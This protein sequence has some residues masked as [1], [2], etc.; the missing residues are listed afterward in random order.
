M[1]SRQY[2][3]FSRTN[4]SNCSRNTQRHN[5]SN[6][7]FWIIRLRKRQTNGTLVSA[8]IKIW[9]LEEQSS[10]TTFV[11]NQ[12]K[13][14][15]IIHSQHP[16]IVNQKQ[17]AD[18]IKYIK[19]N[20]FLSLC[21]INKPVKEPFFL[22]GV[23]RKTFWAHIRINHNPKMLFDQYNILELLYSLHIFLKGVACFSCHI[24][25]F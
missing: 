16:D 8:S 20:S 15:N 10:A 2:L 9:D 17:S 11:L 21:P 22:S 4:V 25:Y 1:K 5:Q 3:P 12:F 23:S 14:S 7:F 19:S 24:F 13:T 18:N 6:I